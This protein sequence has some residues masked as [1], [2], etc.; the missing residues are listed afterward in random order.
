M[1]IFGNNST[2]NTGGSKS[3]SGRKD[4]T[5]PVPLQGLE[6]V[7]LD[8]TNTVPQQVE[9]ARAIKRQQETINVKQF[10]PGIYFVKVSD[11]EKMYVQKLIVE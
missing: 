5:L 1:G 4:S 9:K 6:G 8:G 7:F 2:N 3:K 10:S 11:E